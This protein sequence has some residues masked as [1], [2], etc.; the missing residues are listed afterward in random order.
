M[1][2]PWN[3]FGLRRN[4]F[5]QEPLEADGNADLSRFFV[6]RDD[7]RIEALQRLTHDHQT[8]V[9]LIGDPGVGKTTLMNRLLA[10]LKEGEN[11]RP[12]WLV[13]E[14]KPINLPGAATLTDFC[15]EVLRHVLDLRR[16]HQAAAQAGKTGRKKLLDTAAKAGKSARTV[17][18]PG[19]EDL[20]EVVTRAVRGAT[21]YSPQV[22]GFGVATQLVAPTPSIA[23]WVPL[24][25]SALNELVEESGQDIL[26]AVNNAENLAR[27]EADRAQEVLLDARD[28]FLVPGVHWLFVG[29][30]DFHT[31]VVSP[32]RQLSSIMQHPVVL[33]PLDA[34]DVKA[35]IG[36]RYDELRLPDEPF[37]P[38]V[39]LDTAAQLSRIFV[40][41]LRE[42]L[43]ALETAVLRLAPTGVATVNLSE[44]MQVVSHQQRALLGGKMQGASWEHL[45]SV[46]L[47]PTA[48]APLIRRFR[49]ADAVRRLAPISQPAVNQH[50]R[51][52]IDDGLVRTDGRTG[53]S[54]WLT[55]AGEALLALL[56]DALGQGKSLES[57]ANGRDLET[58]PLPDQPPTRH[59][60]K[61]PTRRIR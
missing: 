11:G 49:E 41:D 34:D 52:W 6:G 53:A 17:V 27:K 36:R 51:Q 54:E 58:E 10:D 23:S 13:P 30:P 14:T 43:R 3:R 2:T 40:G 24:T 29:T 32:M 1:I 28:L 33:A 61:K 31:R 42:L 45:K 19:Q 39:E 38:P 18:A 21:I 22:A 5:F 59:P 56:P 16:Q 57:L 4:P 20:W 44:A 60:R 37:I 12:A 9:V 50:K 46:V 55:V 15:V 8:R 35:L 25:Q 26:I 7:V 48:E 47:G